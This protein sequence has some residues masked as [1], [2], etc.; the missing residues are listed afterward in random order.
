MVTKTLTITEEAYNY[1]KARKLPGQSFSQTIM[2]FPQS[3]DNLLRFAGSMPGLNRKEWDKMRDEDR[4]R[5]AQRYKEQW[6]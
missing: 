1:L 5:D 2:A 3:K 6:G 4:K